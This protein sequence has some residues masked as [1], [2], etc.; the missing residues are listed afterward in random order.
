LQNQHHGFSNVSDTLSELHQGI[1]KSHPCG[2]GLG[3]VGV[4][5][6]G[7][8]A[9]CHRFV[10]SDA[11]KL[12]NVRTGLDQERKNDFLARGNVANKY[13]C[14]T[15]WARP[16]CAGGCH[17]EAFVRYGDTGHANLHYCDWIREWTDICLRI[18]GTLVERNPGY[19]RVFSERKPE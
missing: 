6:S 16:L 14:Q 3:L 17:H 19:L 1:S 4:G 13:D 2:A 7:D 12:G 9:P 18:Y 8:I 10:D 11:H 5:P 15:C